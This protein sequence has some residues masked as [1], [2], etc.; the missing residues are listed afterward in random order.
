MTASPPPI[1][2]IAEDEPLLA[3]ALRAELARAWPQ[4]QVLPPVGD[5]AS[6]VRVT[7]EQRPD[8]LFLDIRM[9]GLTGL[10]AAAA[11]LDEWPSEAAER[12]P[13]IVFVTAYDEYAARAFDVQAADYLLKPVRPERL[14]RTVERL[15]PLLEA[16]RQASPQVALDQ[17]VAR[18]SA[19]LGA[20][21]ASPGEAAALKR[22]PLTIIQAA[23]ST[24]GPDGALL[25]LVPVAEVVYFEAADKYVR[26]L[27]A[28]Q[29][30][31]IR[32]PL[33]ELAERL[34][35]EGPGAFWQVHRS[36]LVRADAIARAQRD[37][38]G[39]LWLHLNARAE[40]LPVS[41]VHAARFKAM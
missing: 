34:P 8:L 35:S 37:E 32:T 31:L 29:E 4:L 28:R 36:L 39:R 20:Q 2:L 6:A 14:A 25:D 13:L 41:R 3:R 1:A 33:K 21:V 40:R 16:R 38:A 30:W 24:A 12:A 23:P 5:G 19:L 18:L 27:T 22:E 26:V 9:P 17:A 10:E 11:V 15:K 7:L